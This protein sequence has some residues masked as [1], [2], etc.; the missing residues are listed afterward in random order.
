M[1]ERRSSWDFAL[2]LATTA[3]L[4]GLGVQSLAG[5]LYAWWATRSIEGWA[6]SAAYGGYIAIMNA[7]AAPM[8][9]ALAIVMGLCVPKRLLARRAL[10]GL[11]VAICAAG[12][13]AWAL[14]GSVVTGVSV[15][16]IGAGAIQVAVVVMTASGARSVRY[17]TEGRLTKVGSGLLHLGFIVFGYVIVSLQSHPAMLPVFWAAFALTIGGSALSFY[18]D[19]IAGPGGHAEMDAP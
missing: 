8:V 2:M 17:L 9:L 15:Y 16:L 11:S 13:V 10:V 12:A 19:R 7:I 14:T 1:E 18:A 5:T 3:L 6:D 4:G